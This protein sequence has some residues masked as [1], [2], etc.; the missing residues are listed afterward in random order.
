MNSKSLLILGMSILVNSLWVTSAKASTFS[1]SRE[2]DSTTPNGLLSGTFH[3]TDNNDNGFISADEVNLFE[4]TFSDGISL[5]EIKASEPKV[6][7][8][9]RYEIGTNNLTFNVRTDQP[10][11]DP[12][13]DENIEFNVD[14]ARNFDTFRDGDAILAPEDFNKTGRVEEIPDEGVEPQATVPEPNS[15]LAL[16]ILGGLG[17][18][19]IRKK[20]QISKDQ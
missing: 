7:A 19:S 4:G 17:I 9:F 5:L 14:F 15:S 12:T 1:F 8:N 13:R 6:F 3:A 20:H 11:P 10:I 16:L 18:I 2:Y